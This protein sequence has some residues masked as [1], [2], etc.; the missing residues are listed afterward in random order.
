MDTNKDKIYSGNLWKIK[1]DW[2]ETRTREFPS[3]TEKWI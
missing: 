1:E 3:N 2:N